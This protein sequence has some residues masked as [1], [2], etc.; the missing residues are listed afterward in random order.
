VFEEDI[1]EVEQIM[2][3]KLSVLKPLMPI[4]TE[5]TLIITVSG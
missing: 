3:K 5:G 1:Q 2:Q 4:N